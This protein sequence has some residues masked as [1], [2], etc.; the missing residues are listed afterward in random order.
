MTLRQE[1]MRK[2]AQQRDA[3][4]ELKEELKEVKDMLKVLITANPTVQPSPPPVHV[5][6]AI[7]PPPEASVE[8]IAAK[9]KD[10]GW[11][12]EHGD[13]YWRCFACFKNITGTQGTC[14]IDHA[15]KAKHIA[16][17]A[18]WSG[19]DQI[20]LAVDIKT[21]MESKNMKL[22]RL[23]TAEESRQSMLTGR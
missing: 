23:M 12:A 13:G 15:G 17:D 20:Q 6:P 5:Q 16:N 19:T 11:F 14:P 10:G 9:I 4:H 22:A 1:M 21:D 8:M 3:M 18:Y 7:P 2:E